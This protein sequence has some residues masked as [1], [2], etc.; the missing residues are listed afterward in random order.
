[1]KTKIYILLISSLII[2]SSCEVRQEYNIKKN[3][4]GEY[5]L[6]LDFSELA[7]NDS[8]IINK[9]K[10]DFDKFNKVIN[11]LKKIQGLTNLKYDLGNNDGI[12]SYSYNFAD[13]NSLNTA[14]Q[15]SSVKVFNFPNVKIKKGLFGKIIYL[16]DKLDNVD[17][18]DTKINFSNIIKYKTILSF[19]RDIKKVKASNGVDYKIDKNKITESGEFSKMFSQKRKFKIS[20][21]K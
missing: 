21:K 17:K 16:R 19:D 3:L 6:T 12:I 7:K 1:M 18:K 9:K 8:S 20:L 11:I 2:L 5:K 4:S 15:E 10:S 13:L 14:L